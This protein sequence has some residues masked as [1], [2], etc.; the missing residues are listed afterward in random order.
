[1]KKLMKIIVLLVIICVVLLLAK[2]I[3]LKAAIENGVSLVTGLGLN[4]RTFKLGIMD[5]SL[6]IQELKIYNP[7]DYEEPVML[8]MPEI[9]VDFNVTDIIK[10]TVHLESLIINLQKFNVV[11]NKDGDVNLNALKVVQEGEKKEEKPK[12]EKPK[13]KGKAPQFQL[14]N[15]ELILGSI[16]FIDYSGGR[17][18]PSVNNFK[19]NISEKYHDIS[20]P[21][22]IMAII[23][24]KAFLKASIAKISGF[25]LGGIQGAMNAQV[26]NLGDLAI[27]SFEQFIAPYIDLTIGELIQ[28]PAFDIFLFVLSLFNCGWLIIVA[29][30]SFISAI[31]YGVFG[32]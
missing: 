12:E 32:R 26:G 2:N 8:D 22:V 29:F 4:M 21:Q 28:K 20:N 16:A 31:M 5:T 14:D 7:K 15:L 10:G 25:D 17:T 27:Y 1:M 30:A 3:I 11:K 6:R 13:K 19:F 9:F 23:L 18:Q 24:Q